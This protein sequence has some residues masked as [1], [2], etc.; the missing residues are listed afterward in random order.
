MKSIYNKLTTS[1]LSIRGTVTRLKW[2]LVPPDFKECCIDIP[3]SV[4]CRLTFRYFY[5]MFLQMPGLYNA[6]LVLVYLFTEIKTTYQ[7]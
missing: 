1:S 4:K 7:V 3:M 2:S 6:I 5:N